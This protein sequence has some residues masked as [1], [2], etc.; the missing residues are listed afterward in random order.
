MST[1]FLMWSTMPTHATPIIISK[2]LLLVTYVQPSS[3]TAP[4]KLSLI[5]L[6]SMTCIN[7]KVTP[8]N[9]TMYCYHIKALELV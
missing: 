8:T 4:W 7:A 3:V 9:E 6:V 2:V 5:R 1:K